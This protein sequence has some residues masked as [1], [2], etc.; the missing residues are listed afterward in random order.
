MTMS[1]QKEPETS[2]VSMDTADQA[3]KTPNAGKIITSIN[4]QNNLQSTNSMK[5]KLTFI[6]TKNI[7]F[8]SLSK[9]SGRMQPSATS[10]HQAAPGLRIKL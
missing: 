6:K 2:G 4:S 10:T 1:A 8:N 5:R 7:N 3:N 9:L